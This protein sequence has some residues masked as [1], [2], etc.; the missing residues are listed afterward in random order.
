METECIA[1]NVKNK[2]TISLP[3]LKTGRCWATSIKV[4]NDI[5]VIGGTDKPSS[6]NPQHNCEMLAWIKQTEWKA[7]PD[8]LK[9]RGYCGSA[10]FEKHIF[11]TG[12]YNAGALKSCEKFDIYNN[13]WIGFNN[14]MHERFGHGTKLTMVLFTAL[15][16]TTARSHYLHVKDMM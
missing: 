11:V 12:G 15:E 5:F 9:A 13:K 3:N 6:N 4:G 10:Y 16:V 8:L 1:Y 7:F 14:M 2:K